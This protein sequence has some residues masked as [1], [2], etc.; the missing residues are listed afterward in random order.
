[1]PPPQTQRISQISQITM[2]QQSRDTPSSTTNKRPSL[3]SAKAS[4]HRSFF[5]IAPPQDIRV[6]NS[7]NQ[8]N[9]YN[10]EISSGSG[11][12]SSN[13]S[14]MEEIRSFKSRTKHFLRRGPTTIDE[15]NTNL[16]THHEEIDETLQPLQQQSP[17]VAQQ[18]QQQQQ[19]S[20]PPPPP[21]PES[22]VERIV[23]RLEKRNANRVHVPI[24]V[25]NRFLKLCKVRKEEARRSLFL[26]DIRYSIFLL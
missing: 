23:Q 6:P 8:S 14:T 21:L 24:E 10:E 5:P 26:Y 11:S 2:Q 16:S 13:L 20:P 9:I 19:V 22:D 4:S 12:I 15:N 7:N 1:M 17:A 3:F 25:K 18:Q